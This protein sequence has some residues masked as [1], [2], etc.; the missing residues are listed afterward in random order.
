[1]MSTPTPT[2][3]G[4]T[5]AAPT[6]TSSS[7]QSDS[8]TFGRAEPDGTVWVRTPA[9][10]VNVGQYAA[11]TPEEGLAFFARKY[12]DLA[13]EVDLALR[14]LREGRTTADAAL[15]VATKAREQL[16]EPRFVG[17]LDA[18]A[19]ACDQIDAEI[20]IQR[21]RKSAERAQARAAALAR[22]EALAAEA[23]GL[24]GS[25]QWKSTGDRFR[26][27]LEEWKSLPHGDRS[28]E[29]ALWKRF[30]AARSAFDKARRAHFAKLEADRGEAST[31]K[32]A[33]I[34]EAER[35]ATS[36]DWGATSTAYRSLVDRWKAAPRASRKEE[37]AWW[38]RFRA[39]QDTFF[40][41]RSAADD[42]RD[43]Q[44]RGN[45]AVKEQLLTEAQALLPITDPAQAGKTLRSIQQRWEAAGAVPRADRDRVEKAMRSVE[46]ALRA[47]E[48]ERWRRTDPAK[49]AFA[50]A[51]VGTFQ[52][53][54]SK[55]E[56]A[57]DKAQQSGDAAAVAKAEAS[58]ASTRELL[59]A[60]ERSL[61]EY[62]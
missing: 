35:L 24:A 4:P 23:E 28:Q 42:E 27:L 40:A 55:L 18:L 43:E 6:A 38:A 33:I 17:D 53:S 10:E 36:T 5:P 9:G 26:T 46:E 30:S 34:A 59:A 2:G 14:R 45:L 29:Q 20:V 54:L 49:R 12:D 37:D 32:E 19:S 25:T 3:I 60:A 16:V 47:A 58:I 62:S 8:V 44:L 61:A 7:T 15:A 56:A 50:E 39:A 1:M 51:T 21:E 13:V 52:A 48:G 11:G 41:A 22:R 57:R 31:A